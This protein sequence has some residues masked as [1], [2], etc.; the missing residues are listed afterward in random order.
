MVQAGLHRG[1]RPLKRDK[2]GHK[3]HQ[4][5]KAREVVPGFRSVFAVTEYY[6]VSD[7]SNL[8]ARGVVDHGL[9][10]VQAQQHAQAALLTDI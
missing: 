6:L 10:L 1:G 2:C 5:Q 8:G 9:V 4:K 7:G 3:G